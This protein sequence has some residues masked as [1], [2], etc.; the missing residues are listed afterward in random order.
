[1]LDDT[2]AGD[3]SLGQVGF[4]SKLV[5]TFR[6]IEES[7]SSS[8]NDALSDGGPGGAESVSDSV[9]DLSNFDLAGSS[10]LDDTDTAFK[11]GQSFLK[12]LLVVAGFSSLDLV[13]NGLYSFFKL[14]PKIT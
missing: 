9:L 1:M 8:G 11:F 4:V 5:Q 14:S 6:G 10:D 7:S 2:N 3:F 12:F 13:L